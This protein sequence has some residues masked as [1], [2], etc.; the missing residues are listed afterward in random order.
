M[1]W[2]RSG[3]GVPAGHALLSAG[4]EAELP[5]VVEGRSERVV[6]ADDAGPAVGAFRCNFSCTTCYHG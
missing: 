6:V 2:N 1:P 4:A 5:D 3:D